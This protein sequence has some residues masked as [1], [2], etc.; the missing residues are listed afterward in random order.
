MM[1]ECFRIFRPEDN[2]EKKRYGKQHIVCAVVLAPK[3]QTFDLIQAW[4]GIK[5]LYC[6]IMFCIDLNRI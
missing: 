1:K 6:I 4:I 3:D 5:R 2:R